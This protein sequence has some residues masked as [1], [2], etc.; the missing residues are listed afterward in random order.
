M[1]DL[2]YEWHVQSRPARQDLDFF[3][4]GGGATRYDDFQIRDSSNGILDL[5]GCTVEAE[6]RDASDSLLATLAASFTAIATGSVR[7]SATADVSASLALPPDA[8]QRGSR[9]YIG[10]YSVFINDSAGRW[11]IKSGDA[12]GIRK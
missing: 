11:C 10:R 4:S 8:A 12:Y 9:L 2:P 6:L 5:T 1:A 3:I 7:V